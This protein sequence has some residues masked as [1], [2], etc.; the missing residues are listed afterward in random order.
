MPRGWL[1]YFLGNVGMEGKGLLLVIVRSRCR[2]DRR[3][4]G[5]CR[6]LGM[7]LAFLVSFVCDFEVEV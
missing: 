4:D 5:R 7:R 2:R 6:L 3:G 1:V